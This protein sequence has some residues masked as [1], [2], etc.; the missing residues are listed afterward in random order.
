MEE[1]EGTVHSLGLILFLPRPPFFLSLKLQNFSPYENT[2][3][4]PPLLHGIL[5]PK[6]FFL[7]SPENFLLNR[8]LHEQKRETKNLME[9][10]S[11]STRGVAD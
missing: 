2:G 8:L 4:W 10:P 9:R 1:N 5:S 3:H 6:N 11:G 7:P